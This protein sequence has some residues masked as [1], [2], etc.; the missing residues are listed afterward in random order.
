MPPEIRAARIDDLP[1]LRSLL[2]ELH[3]D[4]PW[5]DAAARFTFD[6]IL[7]DTRRRLLLAVADGAP[8]GTIDVI[9]VPNL[10]RGARPYAVIENVVVA[11][12][13]RRL[14]IGRALLDAA[15]A[16]ARSEGCYKLQLISAGRR[17][18]AHAFYE[19]CGFSSAFQG[20]RLYL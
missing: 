17:G 14:G 2:A 11:A 4:D 16:H 18:E 6:A 10:T 3:P 19:A 8:A 9:V 20:Y 12:R 13:A 1:A 5:D 15:V 7:A